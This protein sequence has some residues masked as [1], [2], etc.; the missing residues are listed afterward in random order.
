M[1]EVW[2]DI[3]GF[4]GLYQVSNLGNVKRLRHGDYKCVQGYHVF[5]EKL[6]VLSFDKKGYL[7][8]GLSKNNK[9]TMRRVHRLV[10]E[11]FIPNPNEYPMI[12]HKDENKTNNNVNNLEW[13]DARYN[14]IYSLNRKRAYKERTDADSN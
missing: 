1:D 8:V 4:E 11:A 7:Q 10:A 5:P 2:K 6:K 12:N 13:C 3:K 9:Q 14:V